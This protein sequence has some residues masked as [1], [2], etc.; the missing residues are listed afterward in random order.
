MSD[1]HN[2]NGTGHTGR[3]RD[4]VSG[5]ETTG[6]EWDGIKELNTPLPRWWLWTFY[7]SILYAVV[8][9]VLYPA[10]PYYDGEKW[11]HTDGVLGYHQREVV[12]KDMAQADAAQSG[13]V[14]EIRDASYQEIMA[15]D[16]L[17]TFAN[18][19]GAAA[20]GD[21]CAPCHG[22][23]AQGFKGFPNLNDDAWLWG[24]TLEAIETT[25]RHG[26]RWEKDPATRFSEMPR[27]LDDQILS[28]DEVLNVVEYVLSLSGRAEYDDRV[29][30]GADIFQTQ[31]TSCHGADGK[32][33]KA[34]GAP[35]LTDAIWL[36]GGDRETVYETVAHSR[37]GVMPSWADRLDQATIKQLTLY[38][39][40]LGGGVATDSA[41]S[42]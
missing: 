37:R 6:H 23:G 10:I 35:D 11:D 24:G 27:F 9:V 16:A 25:I 20:F 15:D 39:H 42:R 26:I 30:A 32:G 41:S 18:R 31:C 12:A 22:S 4:A 14:R 28:R 5:T 1:T 8:Y 7:A 19:G 2:T 3:E 29:K 33:M 13:Y 21:N 38:V 17:R 40:G 34:L 36:Y